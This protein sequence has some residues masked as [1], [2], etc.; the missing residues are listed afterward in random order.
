MPDRDAAQGALHLDHAGLLRRA[1]PNEEGDEEQ[2]RVREQADE[3]EEQRDPLA[4]AGGDVRG[5]CVFHAH[6]QQGAHHSPAI[7]RECRQQVEEHQRE[8]DEH[9]AFEERSLRDAQA[10]ERHEQRLTR[11]PGIEDG[12]DDGVDGRPGQRHP[13]LLPRVFGHALQPGEAA[14]RKQRDVTRLDPVAPRGQ[15]VP[16]LVQQDAPE[17]HQHEPDAFQRPG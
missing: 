14:D 8:V 1:D 11:Q 15:G 12:G 4:E 3:P 13:Q 10:G 5:P 17:Q 16:E 6:R 2:E 9:H 7:H